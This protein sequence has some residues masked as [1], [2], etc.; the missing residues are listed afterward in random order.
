MNRTPLDVKLPALEKEIAD[1]KR[2][3]AG[4]STSKA[5]KEL[6]MKLVNKE[7]ELQAI[8]EK[9]INNAPSI[10]MGR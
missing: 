1:L 9:Q 5:W 8:I 4:D 3:L 7:G 6:K 2:C 10:R